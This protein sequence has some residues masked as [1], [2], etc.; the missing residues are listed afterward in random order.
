MSAALV[1]SLRAGGL[2]LLFG[3]ACTIV[4]VVLR[5]RQLRASVL[6]IYAD[7]RFYAKVRASC[8]PQAIAGVSAVAAATTTAAA[9]A[10][11]AY[12]AAA[13]RWD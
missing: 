10:A 5:S 2:A 4:A 12:F 1:V 6:G 7:P 8:A 3:L 9:V 13:H 11:A